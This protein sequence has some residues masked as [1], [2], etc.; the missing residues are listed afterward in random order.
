MNF[1]SS[2]RLRV[3]ELAQESKVNEV[4]GRTYTLCWSIW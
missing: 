2:E 3:G 1:W 4:K